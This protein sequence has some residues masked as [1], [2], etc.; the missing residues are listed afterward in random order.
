MPKIEANLKINKLNTANKSLIK[1]WLK[2]AEQRYL[3]YLAG[4]TRALPAFAAL[5]KIRK[6]T[7]PEKR[8]TK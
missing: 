3:D 1:V 8:P 6:N 5:E 4:K 7:R 2:E